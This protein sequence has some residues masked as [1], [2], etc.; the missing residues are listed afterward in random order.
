MSLQR[1]NMRPPNNPFL[2][3]FEGA[4]SN[5]RRHGRLLCQDV[6]CNLGKVLDLSASGLRIK[7]KQWPPKGQEPY[8]LLLA[9]GDVELRLGC[10]TRWRK[11]A[12]LF[13]HEVGVE[14]VHVTEEQRR[15]LA[16]LAR[17]C[18]YNETVRY[19]P[20]AA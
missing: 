3:D 17:A 11:R 14:L 2:R 12:G 18:A 10:V 13:G 8:L 1:L 16:G 4:A 5:N 19:V 15:A 20:D 6:V 7:V 9:A